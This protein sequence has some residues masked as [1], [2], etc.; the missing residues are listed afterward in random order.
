MLQMRLSQF[1]VCSAT[2]TPIAQVAGANFTKGVKRAAQ[3]KLGHEL[4]IA[5]SQLPLD[6]FQVATK[7]HYWAKW[8]E[9]WGEN[10]VDTILI[11]QGNVDMTLNP[12]EVSD[13]Q[14]VTR[15]QLSSLRECTCSGSSCTCQGQTISCFCQLTP[16][17]ARIIKANLLFK[18]WDSLHSITCDNEIHRL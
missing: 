3:R 11:C 7:V 4:G 8:N 18:W 14:Y 15:E 2:S 16:W 17:F 6:M 1:W 5:A 13:V 9:T 10:E 12:S